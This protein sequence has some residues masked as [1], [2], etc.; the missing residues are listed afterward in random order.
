MS[1]FHQLNREYSRLHQAKEEAFWSRNMGLSDGVSKEFE[2]RELAL[3][4]F[5]NNQEHYQKVCRRL[6]QAD[7]TDEEQV[8]LKGWKEFFELNTMQSEEAFAIHKELLKLEG[9]IL[10]ARSDFQTGYK[11]PK[12]GEWVAKTF[13]ELSEIMATEDSEEIRKSAW[14]NFHSMGAYYMDHGFPEIVKKR[15]EL[16]RSL[17][18]SDYYEYKV[19]I[20]ERVAKTKIFDVLDDL[21]VKTEKL[22][23]DYLKKVAS[24]KGEKALKPWNFLY[25]TGGDLTKKKDPYFK[26]EHAL[27]VWGESFSKLGVDYQGAKLTLDLMDRK[28]KDANGFMHGPVP[29]YYNSEDQIS[30]TIN[31][32]STAVAGQVGAGQKGLATLL[33]EGGHAAHFSNIT[34]PAPC[35]SQEFAPT[36]VA[37]AETQSMFM[38]TFTS[39]PHWL[40]RY[41]QDDSGQ[42]MPKELLKENIKQQ[43][44]QS[45]NFFRRALSVVYTEK[46]IYELS[47][48]EIN[49]ENLLKIFAET[50]RELSAMEGAP[51]PVGSVPHIL[52]RE[53]SA[54]YHGYILAQMGVYQTRDFLLKK[55]GSLVD[56]SEVGK[57]L[58][59]TY[60]Q[61]GNLYTFFEFIEA[62]TGKPFSADATVSYLSQTEEGL[63]KQVEEALTHFYSAAHQSE[64]VHL[65]AQIILMHGDDLIASNKEDSFEEMSRKFGEWV[66]QLDI[67]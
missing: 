51:R 39:D 6:K 23:K 22:N 8:G 65:N 33:H 36:S 27:Q 20:T 45:T 21:V 46:R 26:F 7:L 43:Q 48:D 59:Q 41:A 44:E 30:A 53:A 19:R 24:E 16:A 57:I 49:K 29:A 62:M 13:N 28:G 64:P 12:T 9:K 11:D 60:W 47:N 63:S 66:K 37:F 5:T 3:Q 18:H 14:E 40:V 58:Q 2:Q 17:G 55:L 42:P 67:K 50:E 4:E 52:W 35:F 56:N 61:K 10:K 38:D 1:F 25:A 34:M 32:T 15:N 31:F 54:Y